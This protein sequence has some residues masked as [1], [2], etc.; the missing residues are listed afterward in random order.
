MRLQQR[1]LLIAQVVTIMHID[2]LDSIDLDRL[3]DTP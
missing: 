2:I 1:P 3:Q